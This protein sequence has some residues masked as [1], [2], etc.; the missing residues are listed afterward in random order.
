MEA[1]KFVDS[2]RTLT[3]DQWRRPIQKGRWSTSEIIG[4]FIPWD[5]FVLQKR[6]PYFFTNE[7]LS[8]SPDA[9]EIN[10]E[11]AA[12]SRYSEQG[13]IITEFVETRQ[14]LLNTLRNIDDDLWIQEISIGTK[15]VTLYEY[16][17]GL[18][19][20]DRHHFEH[21]RMKYKQ[22]TYYLL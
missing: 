4:H 1:I 21:I 9:E 18:V 17:Y 8:G 6:I 15:K 12:K 11:A 20:H 16:F 19:Q 3:E 14:Q 5:Q 2:L 13:A 10:Q 22:H 7:E